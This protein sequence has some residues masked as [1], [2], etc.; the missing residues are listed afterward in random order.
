MACPNYPDCRYTR[1]LWTYQAAGEKSYCEKCKGEG[2]LPFRNKDGQIIN[3]AFVYCECH[4]D[5]PEH[6]EPV[7][8]EDF[9]FPVSYLFR[10]YEAEQYGEHL[11]SIDPPERGASPLLEITEPEWTRQQWEYVQNLRGLVNHLQN[12]IN[13]HLNKDKKTKQIPELKAIE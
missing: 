7:S 8:P 11:P 9:D 12:K 4:E 1:A 5:E 6:N 3:G 13:E 2:L 10:S